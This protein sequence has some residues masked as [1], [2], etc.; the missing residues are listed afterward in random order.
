[1]KPRHINRTIK[2]AC[3]DKN[4]HKEPHRQIGTHT[5]HTE[6]VEGDRQHPQRHT[7][8][9]CSLA[10]QTLLPLHSG[11]VQVCLLYLTFSVT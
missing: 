2:R 3:G 4:K 11:A 1:M 10:K 5:T 6:W 7:H 8:T 9:E